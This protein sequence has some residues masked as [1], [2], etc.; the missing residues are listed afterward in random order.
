[1]CVGVQDGWDKD[2][3]AVL[4]QMVIMCGLQLCAKSKFSE[5]KGTDVSSS[6]ETS[7]SASLSVCLSLRQN[8][9]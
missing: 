1:M 2:S 4:D 7:G 9:M 5:L 8:F 3:Q 6:R